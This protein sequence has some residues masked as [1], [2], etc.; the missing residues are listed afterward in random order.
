MSERL[1]VRI[2]RVWREEGMAGI[3]GRCLWVV[4]ERLFG[5]TR[6]VRMR[7]SLLEPL[8]VNVPGVPL[9]MDWFSLDE[10]AEYLAFRGVAETDPLHGTDALRDLL[11]AKDRGFIARYDERMVA[12]TWVSIVSVRAEGILPIDEGEV[13]LFGDYTAPAFRGQGIAAV[14]KRELMVRLR[15][16]GHRTAMLLTRPDN[17]PA[18]RANAKAGFQVDATIHALTCGSWH[19]LWVVPVTRSS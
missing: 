8:T 6:H 1:A 7:R 16:E 11:K 18:L 4:A 2:R 19:R 14:L 10:L 5:Y 12:A 9:S 15:E 3:C 13:Y 17:K